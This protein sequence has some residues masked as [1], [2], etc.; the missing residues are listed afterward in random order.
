[1]FHR[2]M[3]W[4][5]EVVAT[6]YLILIARL[7]ISLIRSQNKQA[8]IGVLPSR[9]FSGHNS[10][11]VDLLME[12]TPD[13]YFYLGEDGEEYSVYMDVMFTCSAYYQAEV[14]GAR[15]RADISLAVALRIWPVTNSSTS[16]RVQLPEL[17]GDEFRIRSTTLLLS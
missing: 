12:V 7:W 2:R 17:S 9:F 1:M 15:D 6:L 10:Q 3:Y 4:C 14:L 13:K 16:P 8:C 5:H 11:T